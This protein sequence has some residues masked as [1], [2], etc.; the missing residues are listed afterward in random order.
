MHGLMMNVPL[1][2]TSIMRHAERNDP[3]REIVSVTADAPLH[4]Y[5]YAQSFQRVRQLAN[6]LGALGLTG[7]DRIATLAWNDYR[8]FELYY[9]VS[10]AGYVLHT[11]N[12]RLF[13]EQIA[14]VIKHA[15]D[16]Y[17]FTDVMFLPLLEKL[18]PQL[19][20]VRGYVV[21]T[22]EAHMPPSKLANLMCYET[23]VG[24]QADTYE[25]PELD[26]NTASALCYTSGTTGN[27]KGVLYS[28]RA[29]VLHAYAA[30]L[31]DVMNLSSRDVV[32]PVVPLFHANGWGTPYSVPMVGG[33][34]VFPGP[35]LGDGET[36]HTLMETEGVT[37]ALGVPTVWLGLLQHMRESGKRFSTLRRTVV[38]G[39]ACPLAIMDE[40][41]EK[42]GVVTHHAWGM[43]EMSPLGT[44]NSLKSGMEGLSHDELQAVRAKQG[45]AVFGVA[46]KIVDDAGIDQPW[47][48]KTFGDLR[49]RGP[50]IAS[51]Y[52]RMAGASDAFDGEGW[53]DT[54]DVATIDTDGYMQITD[55]T[56]D[57]IKSGGEWISSIDLENAAVSHP[58]IA[59]AAVIGVPHPKWAERPLLIVVRQ[60]GAEIDKADISEFLADKVARWWL[61][62]DV[63]FVEDI[64]HTATGKISKVTLREQF[65]DYRL[66]TA[67]GS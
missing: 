12:P 57:V 35:K 32:L 54:G 43:T 63:V 33:K 30:A 26:E 61:P 34:L 55:R 38:G 3:G 45:R 23:L 67:A 36:L 60:P 53:F 24:A 46:M 27:P 22:D 8:H 17:V 25:W 29:T 41:R 58:G 48:G 59:E 52:Y 37:V 18:A 9:A 62:D 13:P 14:Y 4:R 65:A 56:K 50:W 10:C 20:N 2:I 6:A 31:P 7:G 51:G 47:D 28:H 66:P 42:Y 5:T 21:M 64:P 11:V 40:F 1:T 39:S 19:A 15:E 44:F 16:R 49:V